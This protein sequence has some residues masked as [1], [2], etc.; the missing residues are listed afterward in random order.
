MRSAPG[1]RSEPEFTYQA[2]NDIAEIEDSISQDNPQAA[3][4]FL[5]LY[6]EDSLVPPIDFLHMRF[7]PW[8]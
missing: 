4:R 1:S 8:Y 7:S 6:L 5:H 3:R 2:V